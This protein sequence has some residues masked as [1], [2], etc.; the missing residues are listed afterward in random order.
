MVNNRMET[1]PMCNKMQMVGSK[2]TQQIDHGGQ[3]HL[4]EEQLEVRV[5]LRLD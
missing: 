1:F 4:R 5:A 3:D 2:E